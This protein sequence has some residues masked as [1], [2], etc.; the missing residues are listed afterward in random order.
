MGLAHRKE[1]H[2]I[3]PILLNAHEDTGTLEY[4]HTRILAQ[5]PHAHQ[6][7]STTENCTFRIEK[8]VLLLTT[9]IVFLRAEKK[10]FSGDRGN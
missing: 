2:R 5:K 1:A 10:D 6:D 7:F 8:D 3:L 9:K 4:L